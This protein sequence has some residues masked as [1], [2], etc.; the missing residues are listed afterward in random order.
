N[1]STE[2]L[3]SAFII[4]LLLMAV[5]FG[6][7]PERYVLARRPPRGVMQK[8]LS[9]LTGA[10]CVM[11]GIAGGSLATPLLKMCSMPV[12]RALAI[13]SGT[14]MIV[15]AAGTMGGIWNGWSIAGRPNWAIG[16]VD[17]VVF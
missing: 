8:V 17:M 9:S 12:T 11:I 7:I 6:L 2:F 5:Y 15:A 16:Y 10:Y 1:V 4:F 13:G 14:S 3:K